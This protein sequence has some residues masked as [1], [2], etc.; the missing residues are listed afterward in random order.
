MRKNKNLYNIFNF[1]FMIIR[2][3][4]SLVILALILPILGVGKFPA[5]I[6][7][8][9]LGIPPILI[10]TILAFNEINPLI[11]E[12]SLAIGMDKYQIFFKIKLPL[13]IP[14]IL[15]GF[16]ISLVEIIASTVLAAYI[17]AGGLGNLIIIGLTNFQ[18]DLLFLTAC[19]IALLCIFVDLIINFLQK[20][21]TKNIY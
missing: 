20:K 17:G 6:A 14:T 11:L 5:I 21:L 3:I 13:A 9:I 8:V 18:L 2:V 15:T 7:L 19:M 12:T 16:K 4:P 10:N 1:F